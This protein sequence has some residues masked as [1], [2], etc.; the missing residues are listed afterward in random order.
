VT[1]EI[2]MVEHEA[3]WRAELS[4][5]LPMP[6]WDFGDPIAVPG[7]QPMTEQSP[8]SIPDSAVVGVH[9][10]KLLPDGSD[11]RRDIEDAKITIGTGFVAPIV[12][13]APNDALALIIGEGIEKVLAAHQVTGAGAWAATSAVRLPGLADL[14][15]GYIET[16]TILVDD[17][18]TGRKNSAELAT[19]LDDRGIEVRM[20]PTGEAS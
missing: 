16:V 4:L 14:V 18:D 5:P 17:N 9:L 6:D 7:I 19:K 1:T 3:R 13:A 8:L 10:I 2:D 15:P 12:L 11:R 20:T